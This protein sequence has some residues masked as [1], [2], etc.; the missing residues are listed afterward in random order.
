[1][2]AARGK[3]DCRR[4]GAC[5]ISNWDDGHYVG[6]SAREVKRLTTWKQKHWIHYES[7]DVER[8]LFPALRTKT[9]R[10]QFHIVCI[11][12][13]GSVGGRCSCSIYDK[14]PRPCRRFRP[15]SF[16]CKEARIEAGIE[17]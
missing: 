14:R 8:K 17:E 6:M 15:G 2:A 1:V 4:C 10:R 3:L 11:A 9:H 12:F 5:C 7:D 13:R 16:E